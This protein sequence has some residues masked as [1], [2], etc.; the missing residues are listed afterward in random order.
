MLK[1]AITGGIASGKSYALK[2]FSSLGYPVISADD[3]IQKI[4]Q[5]KKVLNQISKIFNIKNA[6]KETIKPIVL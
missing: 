5:D 2:Y 6:T 1:V 3:E 4:Y